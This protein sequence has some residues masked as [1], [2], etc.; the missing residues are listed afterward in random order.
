M[1]AAACQSLWLVCDLPRLYRTRL[2]VCGYGTAC[3]CFIV[4]HQAAHIEHDGHLTVYPSGLPSVLTVILPI[5]MLF[6]IIPLTLSLLYVLSC[7]VQILAV[8]HVTHKQI[9][10]CP[11]CA[12][13][14]EN[15]TEGWLDIKAQIILRTCCFTPLTFALYL[16][17]TL[18]L[19]RRAWQNHRPPVSLLSW[20]HTL[21]QKQST[22]ILGK[23]QSFWL[24]MCAGV[25]ACN[26]LSLR[27]C[28]SE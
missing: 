11:V 23:Y 25:C 17:F 14:F 20:T 12:C 4:S 3:I 26:L 28:P 16:F 7:N 5:Y 8:L 2:V 9:K 13:L 27:F 21:D 1:R 6:V 24:C 15:N 18:F 10:V 19:S 22:D